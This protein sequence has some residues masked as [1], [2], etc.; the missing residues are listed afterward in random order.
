MQPNN[1]GMIDNDGSIQNLAVGQ[2]DMPQNNEV[3]YNGLP[4]GQNIEKKKTNMGLIIGCL[5]TGCV[6]VIVI[7]A[8]IVLLMNTI[9]GNSAVVGDWACTRYLY[10][11]NELSDS[12][13]V[14]M[15]LKSDG[16]Y[17]YGEYGNI[18]ENHFAGTYEARA[19]EKEGEYYELS[20][21]PTQEF[22]LNGEQ[23]STAG[24]QMSDMEIGITVGGNGREATLIDEA[25]YT[26]FYCKA[27]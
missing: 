18:E 25:S 22:V 26:T 20:F 17:M 24:R 1:T 21:G 3:N 9:G 13:T 11:I 2:P 8:L 14:M 4:G 6:V 12:P 27:E 19:V 10:S 5:L 16:T 23:Q 7:I 15:K